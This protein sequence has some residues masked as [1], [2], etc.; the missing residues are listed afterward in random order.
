MQTPIIEILVIGNEV[1]AGNVLD[2]NSHWLCQQVASRGGQVGRITVLPDDPREIKD[3]L[4]GALARR[5]ALILTCGGLGPTQDDLT[6]AAVGNA[7]G[8]EVSQDATAY[9]MVRDFYARLHER[10]AV[11]TPDM[12]PARAKMAELPSGAEPLQNRVG[13]APGVLLAHEGVTIVAL[14]GVPAE[15]KDIFTNSLAPRLPSIL[16]EQAYAER[17]VRTQV[18]DESI[19]AP[20]VD[21]VAERHPLVYVKSRAQVY[22]SGTA[23][24]VTLAARGAHENEVRSL[25][26]A[27]ESDLRSELK[28]LGIEVA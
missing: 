17:T 4:L 28:R 27:A 21:G 6:V 14:P 13:A 15:M 5:P 26:D 18:W 9:R 1:L 10:G 16:A 12:L 23:D 25:L 3:G 11:T 20:A 22:G 24:F 19:L 7:L 2:S 8:R